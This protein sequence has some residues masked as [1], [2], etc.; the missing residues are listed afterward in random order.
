M[1]SRV[2]DEWDEKEESRAK[3]KKKERWKEMKENRMDGGRE[4]GRKKKG[5]RSVAGVEGSH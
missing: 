1:V 5:R 2:A 3:G 4:K